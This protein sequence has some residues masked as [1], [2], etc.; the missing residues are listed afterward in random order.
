MSG[1]IRNTCKKCFTVE[2]YDSKLQVCRKCGWTPL[3]EQTILKDGV[4]RK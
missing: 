1:G 4:E 3:K 2:L